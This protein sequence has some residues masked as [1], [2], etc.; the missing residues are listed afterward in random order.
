MSENLSAPR[1]QAVLDEPTDAL[2]SDAIKRIPELSLD[3]KLV[4]PTAIPTDDFIT[5]LLTA[6]DDPRVIAKLAERF[7]EWT[8][9]RPDAYR[10]P[11]RWQQ[12]AGR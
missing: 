7:A 2:T 9:L 11:T 6:L 12:R 1:R 5:A 4:V 10:N 8:E 3:S